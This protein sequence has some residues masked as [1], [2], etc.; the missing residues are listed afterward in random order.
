MANSRTG[1]EGFHAWA[2]SPRTCGPLGSNKDAADPETPASFLG[3]TPGPLGHNDCAD[4]NKKVRVQLVRVNVVGLI[5]GSTSEDCKKVRAEIEEARRIRD[6]FA[7]PK[8]LKKAKEENWDG[9]Q[10]AK[11]VGE[12]VFGKPKPVKKTLSGNGNTSDGPEPTFVSPMGT[13]PLTCHIFEN[14]DRSEYQRRGIPEIIYEADKAHEESHQKSCADSR[15]YDKAMEKPD[16]RSVDEV[17]AYDAKIAI[18]QNWLKD[19]CSNHSR[20]NGK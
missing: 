3:D 15:N 19:H 4:P 8:L 14:W 10:Y 13:D 2:A 6:A 1:L 11:A 17:K 12:K 7:D 20:R 5:S 18:L 16:N 9:Y